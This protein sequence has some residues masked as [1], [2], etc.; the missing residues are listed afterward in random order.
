MPV[1]KSGRTAK[2]AQRKVVRGKEWKKS[3]SIASDKYDTI[4]KAV[5]K[6]L[7]SKPVRFYDLAAKVK[8][9]VPKFPGSVS[10]YTVSALR[11]LEN[12]GKVVRTKGK[13]VTYSKS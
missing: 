6:S 13:V 5:L 9:A 1:K 7:S 2:S 8:K 4:S 3:I 11:A 12:E 10:W